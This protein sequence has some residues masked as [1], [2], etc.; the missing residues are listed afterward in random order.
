MRTHT[1]RAHLGVHLEVVEEDIV[2]VLD[3][4]PHSR[5]RDGA[6]SLG[7]VATVVDVAT[8]VKSGRSLDFAAVT[9]HLALRLPGRIG[10]T[11]KALRSTS[12]VMRRSRA[13]AVSA[14]QIR[15]DGGRLVGV[16]TVTAEGLPGEGGSHAGGDPNERGVRGVIKT[17]FLTVHPVATS[18]PSVDEL[19]AME[20]VGERTYQMAFHEVLRNVNGVLH[21]GG[22]C[23]AAEC[24]ARCAATDLGAP[25][26]L[27]DGLDV[28]F[29]APGL[30]GPFA[31]KV[32]GTPPQD[33]RLAVSVELSDTGRDG[34]L[35]AL[36]LVTMHAA[37]C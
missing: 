21:G 9:G 16:A 15:D 2:G 28:H 1:L 6:V 30:I 13:K 35:I 20:R 11:V 33:G 26:P 4:G 25:H 19:I 22:A 32:E 7:A 17:E 8:L 10:P 29:L 18:G 3:L 23:L 5:T 12:Q 37:G 36:A 27:V 14:V 31:A 34:R 24:A